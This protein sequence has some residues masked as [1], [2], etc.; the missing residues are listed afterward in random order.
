MSEVMLFGE[1]YGHEVVV[2]ALI[3]RFAALRDLDVTVTVRSA[4]GGY[5]RMKNELEAFVA[6]L[7]RQPEARPDIL[8]VATDANCMGRRK[9]EEQLLPLLGPLQG[10]VSMVMAIPDPHIERWLLLDSHAFRAALGRGC[11]APPAKCQRDLYKD[12][13]VR[14]ILRAGLR[15]FVG[16]LEH[17]DAIVGAMDIERTRQAD[18]SFGHFM[19]DLDRALV[20]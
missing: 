17:A 9:R 19:A 12:L 2:R 11:D 16:G 1:D 20:G 3:L 13:L 10:L 18:E 5:G 7:L 8:V 14:A 15:P 4:Q 6:G